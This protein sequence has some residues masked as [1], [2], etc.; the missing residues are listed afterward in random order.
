MH[1]NNI[2]G[3]R[4]NTFLVSM[5]LA[6][7]LQALASYLNQ[8]L[9]DACRSLAFPYCTRNQHRVQT[10]K[11]ESTKSNLSLAEKFKIICNTHQCSLAT[12]VIL[13]V[14]QT[15]CPSYGIINTSSNY[16]QVAGSSLISISIRCLLVDR[17]IC[18]A[19]S[20]Y[21]TFIPYC[22]FLGEGRYYDFIGGEGRYY[23]FIAIIL[24]NLHVVLC[25]AVCCLSLSCFI[26]SKPV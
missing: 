18:R 22:C 1:C 16:C 5:H 24:I 19:L 4:P 15:K 2:L 21:E 6:I 3:L 8:D 25:R 26:S 10:Y 13:Y 17:I 14:K 7:T 12:L 9:P 23:D 11:S 20:H